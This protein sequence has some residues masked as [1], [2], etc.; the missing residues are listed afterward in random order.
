M[1]AKYQIKKLKEK[2]KSLRSVNRISQQRVG[3]VGVRLPA[4][5]RESGRGRARERDR[6]GAGRSGAAPQT[7][8]R[9][10][11]YFPALSAYSGPRTYGHKVKRCPEQYFFLQ[12]NMSSLKT[13]TTNH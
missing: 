6:A 11:R 4:V 9:V 13:L 5:A 8:T 12:L 3:V 7:S 1:T 2:P 10:S